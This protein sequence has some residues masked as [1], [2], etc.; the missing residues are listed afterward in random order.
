MCS[1]RENET[2][3]C[4]CSHLAKAGRLP[5]Q[6]IPVHLLYNPMVLRSPL[7]LQQEDLQSESVFPSSYCMEPG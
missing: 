6:L 3:C 2:L 7:A 1:I 4:S 5:H